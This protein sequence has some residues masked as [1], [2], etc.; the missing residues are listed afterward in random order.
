MLYSL[1]WRVFF[2]SHSR[3]YWTEVSDLG[4]QMFY[5][6]II[7]QT[8]SHILPPTATNHSNGR[9]QCFCSITQFEFSGAMTIDTS[10]LERPQIYFVKGQEIWAMDLEGCRCWRVIMVPTL[11]GKISMCV[12][13]YPLVMVALLVQLKMVCILHVFKRIHTWLFALDH[14]KCSQRIQVK[15]FPGK[16]STDVHTIFWIC[17]FIVVVIL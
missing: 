15:L 4:P 9:K 14:A 13:R 10:D 17:G 3:L 1:S 5:Y 8:L 6:S 16:L 11:L 7:N 12:H 2:F